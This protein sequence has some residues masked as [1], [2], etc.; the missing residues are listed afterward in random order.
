MLQD[1]L[2]L[3]RIAD[4]KGNA[5]KSM[6]I[7]D[8]TPADYPAITAI[9]QSQGIVWPEWPRTPDEWAAADERRPAKCKHRRWVAEL[10]GQTVGFGSY[11]Q[12]ASYYHPQR[13]N[14]LVEVTPAC[15]QRGI[16]SA[17]YDTLMCDL[18]AHDPRV[19][20][21]DAFTN[22]PQGYA[23]LQKRGFREVFRETPVHLD[24]RGFDPVR[25]AQV[26]PSPGAQTVKLKTMR[27]VRAEPGCE[28]KLYELYFEI[29]ADVPSEEVQVEQPSFE[30]WIGW[31]LDDP[32]L[33]QDATLV[34][35]CE[36]AYVG[37]REQWNCADAG[38]LLGGLM[39]VRR[40]FRQRGI[41]LAMQLR[42]IDDARQGGFHLMKDC[43]AVQNAPM[44]AMFT[45][46]GFARDP[47]WQQCQKEVLL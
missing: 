5:M 2:L 24:L 25:H 31:G 10:D 44:Q 21:A 30:E 36:G 11:G 47:E 46:L 34:A 29:E 6:L 22:L 13:F 40:A 26:G 43:T 41:G 38:V 39:G 17:L 27:E 8:F 37:L 3:A 4:P 19:L 15:Q 23:F 7:R 12:S 1:R 18:Q 33:N 14:L 20:R 32:D 28:R 16:G 45:R 35:V 9:H 42:C